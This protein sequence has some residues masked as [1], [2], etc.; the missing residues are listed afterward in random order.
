MSH[1]SNIICRLF[2]NDGGSIIAK[3]GKEDDLPS[4]AAVLSNIMRDYTEYGKLI[5]SNQEL[6]MLFLQ[7]DHALYIA[8]PIYNTVL[9]FICDKEAN[10]G[11]VR[12]KCETLSK[13]LE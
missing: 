1:A 9:C 5:L 7:H 11:I 6:Q 12:T 10:F 13:V 3:A 4:Q 8:Q 2:N